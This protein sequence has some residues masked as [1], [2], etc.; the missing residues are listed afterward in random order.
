MTDVR[1]TTFKARILERSAMS[2]SVMPSAKYS[3]LGSPEKFTNGNTANDF[4][5]GAAGVNC[6]RIMKPKPT[7]SRT[8]TT[9]GIHSH[10]RKLR[11]EPLVCG[12][13]SSA[14]AATDVT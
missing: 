11:R 13:D 5:L 7:V 1:D 6:W 2:A 14:S 12:E 4:T 3:W 10:R 9:P 8:P